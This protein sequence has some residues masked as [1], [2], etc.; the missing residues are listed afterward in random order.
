M[1]QET[2]QT[3]VPT[4]CAMGCGFYGNPRTNGMC[5]VCYKEHLLRQ[6]GRSS[7]PAASSPSSVVSG[8]GGCSVSGESTPVQCTEGSPESEESKTSTPSP[9]TQQMTAMSISRDDSTTEPERGGKEVEQQQQQE[10]KV[11]GGA[12]K[13]TGCSGAVLEAA[14]CSSEGEEKTPDKAKKKNRCFICRK[15]LGLTGFDCRCGNLFCGIHRYSDE[16]S[17]PYDYRAEAAEKIRKE[18]PIV[19]AE[20]I[21]KL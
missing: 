15:K 20:K 4:L 11:E 13:S 17:C 2:N 10:E 1:A 16:H 19:V 12:A 9:V 8:S 21:Q 14:Q 6:Q 7:P 3:Q 5:S 18:N